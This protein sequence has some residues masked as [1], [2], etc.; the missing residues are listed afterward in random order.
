META[1]NFM[2]FSG[3]FFL[4]ASGLFDFDLTFVAETVLFI[5]LALVV[6]FVFLNPISKQLDDRADFINF[7]LR[8]S[9]ILLTFGYEKLSECVGLLTSEVTEMN[10][11]IKLTKSY[12]NSNFEEEV[13]SVQKKNSLLLSK[14]KG[15]LSI[16]SAYL[17]SNVTG[18]L[19]NLTNSFFTK[20]FQS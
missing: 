15:D 1:N 20:K 17:F 19:I 16:K 12:T 5:I 3:T 14:L 4:T 10:R 11:Q 18:E 2:T 8:K 9:T 13:L 6:T 7:N